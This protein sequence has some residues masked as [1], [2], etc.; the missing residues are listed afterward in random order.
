VELPDAIRA[1]FEVARVLEELRIPYLVGGSIASSV[2]GIPRSTEDA[3]L[4]ADLRPQDIQPF[5]AALTTN[6]Y[7]DAERVLHAVRRRSSFNMLHHATGIKVD[8][9]LLKGDLFSLQEMNR[10]QRISPLDNDSTIPVASPEDIILQKLHW[11]QL[12]NCVSDQQWNDVLGVMKVQRK[13]LDLSYLKEWA[14]RIEVGELLQKALQDSGIE[15]L[16]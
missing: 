12:A 7:I 10:R 14:E 4:V 1:T 3:D 13:S 6:F 16:S 5:V 9:F 15:P 11:Y 2:H 8:V